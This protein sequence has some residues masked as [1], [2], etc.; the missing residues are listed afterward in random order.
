MPPQWPAVTKPPAT[1]KPI[2]QSVLPLITYWSPPRMSYIGLG[3]SAAATTETVPAPL[4]FANFLAA[5]SAPGLAITTTVLVATSTYQPRMSLPA[6]AA[7]LSIAARAAARSASPRSTSLASAPSA[8][9][10]AAAA[11]WSPRR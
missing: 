6:L 11:R 10:F 2:E 4:S 3:W 8:R 5:A 7:R 9:A 1:A